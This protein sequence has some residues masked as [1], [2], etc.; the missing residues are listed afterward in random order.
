MRKIIASLDIGSHTIKLV[1]GEIV[2]N[3]LNILACVDTLSRGIK[4]GFI[5]NPESAIE[6]LD[7][8]FKKCEE[9]IGLKI[10]KVVVSVPTNGMECFLSEGYASITNDNHVV[11]GNDIIK[12]MQTAIQGKIM[13]NR[14][15]VA[16]LP[17]KFLLN[18]SVVADMPLGM[19]AE[20]LR[21]KTVV[22]TVPKK[23][24]TPIVKIL[25]K[26][27]VTVVDTT[28]GPIGDY[29][30]FK[31]ANYDTDESNPVISSF[32]KDNNITAQVGTG[33]LSYPSELKTPKY[34]KSL[35]SYVTAGKIYGDKW[36]ILKIEAVKI[37]KTTQPSHILDDYDINLYYFI[38]IIY[39]NII[40]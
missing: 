32:F 18:D 21:V 1:V 30:E 31:N 24:V 39:D 37:D 20:K 7:D 8:V 27:N 16:I 3:K 4:K 28:V 19:Q 33:Y 29:Y 2:R 10:T 36:S 6:A 25:E 15:I 14:E 17:T 34:L 23:N 5:V 38:P 9:Q 22:A 35:N 13:D 40:Y 12:S 26:M 11:T